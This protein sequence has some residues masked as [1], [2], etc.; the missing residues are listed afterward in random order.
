MKLVDLTHCIMH[1][2]HCEDWL[3]IYGV[4]AVQN[5]GLKDCVAGGGKGKPPSSKAAR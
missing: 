2:L 4:V 3:R 5:P 1:V